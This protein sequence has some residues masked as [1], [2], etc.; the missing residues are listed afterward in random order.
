MD[1]L[2]TK[3]IYLLIVIIVGIIALSI[4][5]TYAIFTFEGSTSDV[6]SIN[7][8]GSLN[9]NLDVEE[10]RQ[11]VVPKNSYLNT[12][13]DIYNNFDYNI[14]YSVWYQ[15]I[16]TNDVSPD[17]IT[18]LEN[19]SSTLSSTGTLNSVDKKRI[20]LLIIND[21][22]YET[23]IKIGLS[24]SKNEGTCELQI[25]SNRNSIQS[26]I[27]KYDNLASYGT[28]HISSQN[29]DA[30]YLTYKDVTNKITI[31]SNTL[32]VASNFTYENETFTL[33]EPVEITPDKLNEN[34]NKY[35]CLEG[36]SCKYLYRILNVDLNEEKYQLTKYD[37]LEGYLSG[38]TG[39]RKVGDNYIYFGDNPHNF[40]YYNCAN[41]KDL[42]TCELWRIIG[43]YHTE[44][45]QYITRIIKND[46]LI[47]T[48][49]SD[50]SILWSDSKLDKYFKEEYKINKNYLEEITFEQENVTDLS[51][52]QYN[53]PRYENK[54]KT[55]AS[56][57]DL[58]DYLNASLCKDKKISEF[59]EECLKHNWLNKDDLM[60]WTKTIKHIAPYTDSE[61]NEEVI[62]ENNTVYAVGNTI[63]D[64]NINEELWIRPVVYLKARTLLTGGTG[65]LEEP[66][67][68]K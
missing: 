13:V 62:P 33:T 57:M 10:Y 5:S 17:K 12:D 4:Y 47:K 11:V 6:V 64:I 55:Y 43:Y 50:N 54:Y 24:Y 45:N 40:I 14:C 29:V 20:S 2:P 53:I 31:S 42:N 35:L 49:Y 38:E 46:W 59:N 67:I 25:A 41:E 56:I 39:L 27:D 68:I 1:K 51:I 30:S 3:Q 66:F 18:I 15:V 61:T 16:D 60:T 28:S 22:Q 48:K 19:T 63:N 9:L 26:T 21:N 52:N 8:P 65:T 34:L 37:R 7:T 32:F 36:N 44:D 58:S 23:K